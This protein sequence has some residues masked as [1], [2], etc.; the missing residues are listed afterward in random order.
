MIHKIG[1]AVLLSEIG[2][3]GKH[4]NSF[5]E[6]VT[7]IFGDGSA[8]AFYALNGNTMDESGVHNAHWVGQ[9]DY[10]E[11]DGHTVARFTSNKSSI[12]VDWI[13]RSGSGFTISGWIYILGSA[14]T[15]ANI[16]G[17]SEVDYNDYRY[18]HGRQP[19]LFL[20]YNDNLRTHV[21]CDTVCGYSNY[22]VDRSNS[23]F[24]YGKW[25]HVVHEVEGRN[26]RLYVD[27]V[28]VASATAPCDYRLNSGIFHI[29]DPWHNDNNL[30]S[31]VRLIKRG[32]NQAEVDILYEDG[33]HILE[34]AR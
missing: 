10:A 18:T 31:R 6:D 1:N 26:Q 30:T 9:E 24:Q 16:W 14:G 23:I 7:D 5:K 27:K 8:I 25:H 17:F 20:Y 11:I 3:H 33:K 4:L 12:K 28:L 29:C 19:S 2:F 15:W 34:P 32:V 13:E 21:R 22:G